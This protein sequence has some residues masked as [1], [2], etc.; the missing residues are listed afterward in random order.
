M[1]SSHSN[2]KA[3]LLT[4]TPYVR[5]TISFQGTPLEIVVQSGLI[6]KLGFGSLLAYFALLIENKKSLPTGQL[7]T[8]H[9]PRQ[10]MR[11]E[12]SQ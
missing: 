7:T 2:C 12:L 10:L 3:R 11:S 9:G 5:Q 1:F 6:G 8:K 4:F